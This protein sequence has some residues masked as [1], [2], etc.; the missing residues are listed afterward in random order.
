MSLM[1]IDVG[2]TGCKAATFCEDGRCLAAAYKEYPTLRPQTDWAELDSHAVV[3][4]VKEVI[5]KAAAQVTN[6]PVQAISVSSLGEAM[7]PISA[8]GEILDNSIL[9]ADM[10]GGDLLECLTT[11]MGQK[12][13]YKIN[14]NILGPNYSLPKLLWLK[15]NKSDVYR[16]ADKFLLWGDL[17]T[18]ILSG[19]SLTSFSLANRTLLFDIQNKD[20]SDELLQLCDIERQKLPIPVASGT[21]AGLINAEIAAELNLSSNVKIVIGGH[22]QCCNSLGAGIH[23]A[24]KAV[25]GIG[26]VECITPTY[27]YLPDSKYMLDNGLNIENHVLEGLYVSFIYNQS[28]SLVRWFRDT[29]ASA[30]KRLLQPNDDIYELLV[31]EIPTQPTNLITLPY[32]E[33]S[34]A[35]HFITDATGVIAGLRINTQR[36]EIL[37]SIMECAT[38]YFLESIDSLKKIGIDT[39]EFVATGGGAKSSRW[40]QIKADIFGVPFVR[41]KVVECSTL[42]AAML[43]GIS[44]GIFTNAHD[45]VSQFVRIDRTFEPDATRRQIYQEKYVIYKQ[46]YSLFIS[47]RDVLELEN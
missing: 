45:A 3:Q 37:K 7:T 14:P 5:V 17:I 40:L 25:C 21:I 30:D 15:H 43:A 8:D 4:A 2:T 18:F 20:W 35:P 12:E 29:F 33:A 26:T 46:I 38:F 24:S 47:G 41:P 34:G 36:G 31:R 32:F 39:S 9:G 11:A 1:G 6:D 10:R 13:T 44:V 28:G 27:D 22:D 23:T 42:G 16:K 19:E